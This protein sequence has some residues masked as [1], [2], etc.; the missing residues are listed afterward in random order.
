MRAISL[1]SLLSSL[2]LVLPA[3]SN[4]SD[5]AAREARREVIRLEMEVDR[6]SQALMAKDPALAAAQK[7]A[8]DSSTAMFK[9][10]EAEPSLEAARA[11]VREAEAQMV[12]AVQSKDPVARAK[13][14][15]AVRNATE[16]LYEMAY[17]VPGIAAL[18]D[19]STSAG[20]NL[21]SARETAVAATPEGKPI[22]DQ[23]V[24][25]RKAT[26]Q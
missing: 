21:K 2:A 12:A 8:E 19:A 18:R 25:A 11:K 16:D 3:F 6:L 24:A 9:A 15:V 10:I 5:P 13:A 14:T 22:V 7:A 17:A 23:L 1:V 4:P 26:G 20:K